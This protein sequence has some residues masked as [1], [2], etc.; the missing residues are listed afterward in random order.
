M[1]MDRR[2]FLKTL[3]LA[4]VA[5]TLPKP[6]EVV[7]ARMAALD[8]PPLHVGHV[9]LR[10]RDEARFVLYN[11]T[12]HLPRF[13]SKYAYC[14]FLDNW[15]LRMSFRRPD[16]KMVDIL[17][18][19]CAV[20]PMGDP[21]DPELKG[22]GGLLAGMN[23]LH[24]RPFMMA[25]PMVVSQD[26]VLEFWLLPTGRQKFPMPPAQLCLYGDSVPIT[27]RHFGLSKLY[28]NLSFDAV[29]VERAEA[30][31]L[32]IA[33]ADEAPDDLETVRKQD[34]VIVGGDRE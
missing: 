20:M 12:M 10:P 8:A 21:F 13:I 16:E 6:L 15:Q 24:R 18:A 2:A 26:D 3:G 19:S 29:R 11:F 5:L 25:V 14:D 23:P 9:S 28:I 30:I 7:A 1:T 32:G 17:R 34:L 33:L 27:Q 22:Y 4:G 31:R